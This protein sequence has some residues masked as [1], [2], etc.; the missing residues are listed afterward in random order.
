MPPIQN[1]TAEVTA[2]NRNQQAANVTA[3]GYG[4]GV[5]VTERDR[6][7]RQRDEGVISPAVRPLQERGPNLHQICRTRGVSSSRALTYAPNHT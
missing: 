2:I 3:I 7:N 1:G 5:E 4:M 6:E